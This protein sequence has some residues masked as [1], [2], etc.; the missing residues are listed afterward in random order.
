MS[1]GTDR[2]G[3]PLC[4]AHGESQ[5][6]A[7]DV[8]LGKP[9][10]HDRSNLRSYTY[11]CTYARVGIIYTRRVHAGNLLTYFIEIERVFA[12]HGTVE[13]RFQEAR[14]SV[15]ERMRDRKSVV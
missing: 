14:P 3:Q 10:Y 7:L 15:A 11:V 12:G 4:P 8:G 5:E 2:L 1:A 9:S 6:S 13:P